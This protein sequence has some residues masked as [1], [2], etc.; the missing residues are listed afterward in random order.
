MY[1]AMDYDNQRMIWLC[2]SGYD[3]AA[4]LEADWTL[5]AWTQWK[6]VCSKELTALARMVPLL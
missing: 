1:N 3:F 4:N 2:E 6:T 5:N